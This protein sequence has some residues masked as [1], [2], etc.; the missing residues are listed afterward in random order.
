M[1]NNAPFDFPYQIAEQK[2][3][4]HWKQNAPE[5]RE[6][7]ILLFLHYARCIHF[8]SLLINS[9]CYS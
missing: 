8:G 2:L 9:K 6:V 3:Y 4:D 5:L 7:S 1:L